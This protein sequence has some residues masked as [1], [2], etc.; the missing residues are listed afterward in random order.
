VI[1]VA[2]Y[3]YMGMAA[4]DAYSPEYVEDEFYEIHIHEPA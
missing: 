2:Y 3:S 4:S 1:L